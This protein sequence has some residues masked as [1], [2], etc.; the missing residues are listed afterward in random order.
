[1]PSKESLKYIVK[2]P[3]SSL[4]EYQELKNSR[5]RSQITKIAPS[6]RKNKSKSVFFHHEKLEI[7]LDCSTWTIN[8][9]PQIEL[10]SANSLN[11]MVKRANFWSY[12]HPNITIKIDLTEMFKF[13]KDNIGIE[14]ITLFME[15][16][17]YL[18]NLAIKYQIHNLKTIKT[19]KIFAKPTIEKEIIKERASYFMILNFE[20]ETDENK[21]F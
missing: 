14:E 15:M 1:M 10:V 20:P 6:L 3:R 8:N 12:I 19:Q 7:I 18:F 13:I 21:L 11:F 4:E 9:N 2:H 17:E 5:M 16:I